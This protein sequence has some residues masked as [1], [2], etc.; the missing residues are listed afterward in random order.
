[1]TYHLP[2]F[3]FKVQTNQIIMK[4]RTIRRATIGADMESPTN[5]EA[6]KI[7]VGERVLK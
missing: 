6:I 1:M 4:T 3:N 7:R 5:Y 2:S